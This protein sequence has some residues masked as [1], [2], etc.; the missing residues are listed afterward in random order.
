M[1]LLYGIY[2]E[3]FKPS[4]FSRSRKFQ[5]FGIGASSSP[6]QRGVPKCARS[7][8]GRVLSGTP[9]RPWEKSAVFKEFIQFEARF[10]FEL[11]DSQE[12]IL[13]IP[14]GGKYR[15]PAIQQ[16]QGMDD[17]AIKMFFADDTEKRVYLLLAR[18]NNAVCLA[19]IR[20]K[21]WWGE[22]FWA[23]VGPNISLDNPFFPGSSMM[24]WNWFIPH[25][26]TIRLF[27]RFYVEVPLLEVWTL[28]LPV[29]DIEKC[30]HAVACQMGLDIV[31]RR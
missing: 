31:K 19:A 10:I 3:R 25:L 6:E 15:T 8:I 17:V 20:E 26:E 27:C 16:I 29:G 18:P 30:A 14:N 11:A 21:I 7:W 28:K 24:P 13:Y 1:T 9:T 4:I 2:Q 5:Y 23:I 12:V 22:T